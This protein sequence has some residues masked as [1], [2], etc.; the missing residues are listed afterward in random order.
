MKYY[1]GGKCMKAVLFF[2]TYVRIQHCSLL[3]MYE[4]NVIIYYVCMKTM[5]FSLYINIM[6]CIMYAWI[7]CCSL[8]CMNIMMLF[9]MYA[10]IQCCFL[11]C[12]HEYNIVLCGCGVY[13]K[14]I[15]VTLRDLT[16]RLA[17]V[18]KKKK[19]QRK[20]LFQQFFYNRNKKYK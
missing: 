17:S 3:C 14:K 11:L 2:I 1:C 8:L 7:E 9:F 15:S 13:D 5:L 18:P 19:L 20:A 10:W 12:V 16:P 6:P 4:Y